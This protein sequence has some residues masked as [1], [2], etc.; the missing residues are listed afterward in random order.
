MTKTQIGAKTYM[1][2]MPIVL[3]GAN[4]NGKPNYLTIAY[5]GIA[6]HV[7]PMVSVTMGKHHYTNAGIR[8]N[9]TFSVNIPSEDMVEVTDYVGIYSGRTIDKSTI[10]D[11]FYG[12]L[13]TAPMIR[14]CPLNLE[15]RLVQTVD[16]EGSNELFIGEIVE[17]YADEQC[18]TEDLPDIRKIRPMVFSM[19]D[20][21]YWKI[22]EH[23]GRAW[24][25][26]KDYKPKQV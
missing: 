8:E 13:E 3:V 4:V 5:C 17:V 9:G 14:E 20:N 18:L 12:M 23:I 2:P 6:Q 11:N 21:N 15:C 22:G 19:H 24:K 26:G 10:F 1:Y 25:L 7:P 16:F